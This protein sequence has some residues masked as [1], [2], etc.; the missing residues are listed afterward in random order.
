VGGRFMSHQQGNAMGARLRAAWL[1]SELWLVGTGHW[2]L[3]APLLTCVENAEMSGF[4]EG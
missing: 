3:S 4:R 2:D 1:L